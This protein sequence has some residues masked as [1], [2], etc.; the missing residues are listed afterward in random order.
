MSDILK[1]THEK[2]Q[3]TLSD[4]PKATDEAVTE[5]LQKKFGKKASEDSS[6]EE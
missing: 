5:A 2:I 3:E 4:R 1:K 6:T